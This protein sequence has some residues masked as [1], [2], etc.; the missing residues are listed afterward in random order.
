MKGSLFGRVVLALT[1]KV[2]SVSDKKAAPGVRLVWRPARGRE[3][4]PPMT[5]ELRLRGIASFSG[6]VCFLVLGA[7]VGFAHGFAALQEASF[8]LTLRLVLITG[9]LALLVPWCVGW[10]VLSVRGR[11]EEVES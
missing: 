11:V 2:F 10:L 3:E 1:P 8:G 6:A 5:P 9:L 7:L 4:H